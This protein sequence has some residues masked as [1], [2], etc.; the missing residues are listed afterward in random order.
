MIVIGTNRTTELR[1]RKHLILSG[2]YGDTEEGLGQ[3]H[4]ILRDEESYRGCQ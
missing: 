2:N 4:A 3:F 1:G